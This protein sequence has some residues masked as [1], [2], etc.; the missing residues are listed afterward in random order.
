MEQ[1]LSE[2]VSKIPEA[3]SIYINQLVYA[4]KRK[5]IDIITLSLG[6]AF[7]SIPLYSFEKLDVEK[8][9]H[10]SESMG[11]PE[12]R[13]K[14]LSYYNQNYNAEIGG[15]E[16]IL[17]S[18]GSKPII[19]MALQAVLN[20][21]EE[22]L[23]HE[24]AWLSYEEQVKLA[25][26]I[27]KFIPYYCETENFED[28]FTDKTKVLILNNPNN[29]SGK[30]YT[31]AQLEKLHRLCN[32]R[33]AFLLMD[34]AYSDFVDKENE[35]VSLAAVAKDLKGIIVV[36]SLSKNMGMSGWRIGYVIAETKIIYNILKL[37]QHLITCA[38]TILQ[39]YL[40][41][42]FEQIIA[43]TMP[44]VKEVVAKRKRIKSYLDRIGLPYLEGNATFYF[45]ISTEGFED[46]SIDL[47]MYILFKYGIAA[48]PGNAYGESTEKFIRI[49]IGAE[50]EERIQYALNVIKSVIA[51][52]EVD[53]QYIARRL[54]DNHFHKF[55]EVNV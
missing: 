30:C 42:Y 35:F 10:Y 6:E 29:P 49:G 33:G 23:I 4:E 21:N 17:I 45:F 3:L 22:V 5:G 51:M 27:P 28:Y 53:K 50:S 44:Q 46:S 40:A 41:N 47:C 14:I 48:V 26:G 36:N 54:A 32:Q 39:M 8:S 13:E 19:Y 25:N 15:I 11:L 1:N 43:I 31:K 55:E 24:P 12:L 52:K 34:E 9:Y 37:N 18:S 2:K 7:F 38:P 16:N 20:D